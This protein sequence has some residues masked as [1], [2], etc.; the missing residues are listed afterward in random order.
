[1]TGQEA[2]FVTA[3]AAYRRSQP[4]LN[5]VDYQALKVYYLQ[6]LFIIIIMEFE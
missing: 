4:I 2:H 6:S 3:V 1:M 5:D